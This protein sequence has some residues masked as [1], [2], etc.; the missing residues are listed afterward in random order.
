MTS[1]KDIITGFDIY[2]CQNRH[3]GGWQG[4][5]G[6]PK[7]HILY[8]KHYTAMIPAYDQEEGDLDHFI[9]TRGVFSFFVSNTSEDGKF[10]DITGQFSAHG[11]ITYSGGAYWDYQ[12]W[13]ALNHEPF[14]SVTI[15]DLKYYQKVQRLI[16]LTGN[17]LFTYYY[18]KKADV[19]AM[20]YK[21]QWE[22]NNK[23]QNDDLFARAWR[24]HKVYESLKNIKKPQIPYFAPHQWGANKD[25]FYKTDNDLWYFGWDSAHLGDD[26]Y[27]CNK[28]FATE[29]TEQLA[30]QLF[31][32]DCEETRYWMK[33]IPK[34]Q[35]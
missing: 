14:S 26:S 31:R 18:N 33:E 4:Y 2:L 16:D 21:K 25:Y 19:H 24:V 34:N 20:S 3:S 17:N 23:I 12:E 9:E 27:S 35:A 13:D 11:G 8:N 22:I 1:Y 28:Q 15:G 32:Y 30:L 10:L 5:V 6:L 29:Q 7:D